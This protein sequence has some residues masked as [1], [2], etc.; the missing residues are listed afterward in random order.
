MRYLPPNGE[1]QGHMQQL[2]WRLSYCTIYQDQF[3]RDL[4]SFAALG[5]L[6]QLSVRKIKDRDHY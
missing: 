5:I 3:C 4:S 2:Q 1:E 6:K